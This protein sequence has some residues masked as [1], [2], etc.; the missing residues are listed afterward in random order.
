GQRKRLAGERRR[1]RELRRPMGAG[2]VGVQGRTRPGGARIL[3]RVL[4]VLCALVIVS[5][6]ATAA[7]VA[8]LYSHCSKIVDERLASGY[9]TSRAGIYAAQRELRAGQRLTTN[10]L[11]EILSRSG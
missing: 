2:G 10:T 11:D 8:Y 3:A 6:V 9:L 1:A 7:A 4:C 5:V